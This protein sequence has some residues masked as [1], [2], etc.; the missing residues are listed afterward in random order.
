MYWSMASNLQK[1]T[2]FAWIADNRRL[3]FVALLL[4]V[5]LAVLVWTGPQPA[6][7]VN[8][9]FGLLLGVLI[10]RADLN[11]GPETTNAEHCDPLPLGSRTGLLPVYKSLKQ[12]L[13]LLS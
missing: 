2:I 8:A 13:I 9:A 1:D 7:V 11:T 6:L 4:V 5:L 3:S 12:S 10:P